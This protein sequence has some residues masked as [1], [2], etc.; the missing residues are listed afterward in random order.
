MSGGTARLLRL[1]EAVAAPVLILVAAVSLADGVLHTGG[2]DTFAYLGG[3]ILVGEGAPTPYTLGFERVVLTATGPATQYFPTFQYH[4]A[5]ALVYH[6]LPGWSAGDARGAIVATNALGAALVLG[7]SL[8]LARAA[9]MRW[10]ACGAL[11]LALALSHSQQWALSLGNLSMTT[12]GLALLASAALLA[13]KPRAAGLLFAGAAVFKPLFWL[14]WVTIAIAWRPADPS[15]RR[16]FLHSWLAAFALLSAAPILAGRPYDFGG[17]V[18]NLLSLGGGAWSLSYADGSL[19]ACVLRWLSPLTVIHFEMLARNIGNVEA[20]LGMLLTP[21][22]A[23]GK[24]AA[25]AGGL[26]Y[27]AALRLRRAALAEEPAMLAGIALAASFLLQPVNWSHNYGMLAVV[28]AAWLARVAAGDPR[29]SRA[30]VAATLSMALLAMNPLVP[31]LDRMGHVPMALGRGD[32]EALR[33]D[34]N[35]LRAVASLQTA[36]LLLLVAMPLRRLPAPR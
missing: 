8:W 26:A 2:F 34:W 35:V 22:L 28:A 4:P 14:A 24:A 29:A 23:A 21:H 10:W 9:Q 3:A 32:L 20:Q 36:F 15:A 11:A 12:T 33:G 31:L 30:A 16:R 7:G 25:L 13:G 5:V 19:G 27:I 1:A 6:W 18:A 17:Y